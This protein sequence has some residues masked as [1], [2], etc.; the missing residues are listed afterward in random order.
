MAGR[1]LSSSRGT[2]RDGLGEKRRGFVSKSKILGGNCEGRG[3]LGASANRGER[4]HRGK[5]G[6]QEILR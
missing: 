2:S 6:V 1:G 5:P 3:P 4:D